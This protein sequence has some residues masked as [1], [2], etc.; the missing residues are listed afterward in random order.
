MS[1]IGAESSIADITAGS[2]ENE[3]GSALISPRAGAGIQMITQGR[4]PRM[5]K[6]A[7]KRSRTRK[8][9][10]THA[11]MVE[12]TSVLVM[13]LSILLKVSKRQR[14]GEHQDDR[15]NLH[16]IKRVLGAFSC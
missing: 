13:A 7:K 10:R 1:R 12:S 3:A 4:T 15:E 2:L 16:S 9:C 11:S 6:T 14:H 8:N 5:T